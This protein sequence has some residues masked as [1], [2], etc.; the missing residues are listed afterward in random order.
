MAL[1]RNEKPP[2]ENMVLLS[3]A[4]K[5]SQHN[6]H[7]FR[8]DR[9]DGEPWIARVYPPARP[10]AGVEGDAAI[11]RFLEQ[12]DYP[13]ERLA[14][15]QAETSPQIQGAR[16]ALDGALAKAK[17]IA[18]DPT[19][20]E[21]AAEEQVAA[22]GAGA[23]SSAAEPDQAASEVQAKPETHVAG[24]DEVARADDQP[25]EET[26]LAAP[27]PDGSS[28]EAAADEAVAAPMEPQPEAAAHSEAPPQA[29]EVPSHAEEPPQ[30]EAPSAEPP[31]V[32]EPAPHLEVV[33]TVEGGETQE[34]ASDISDKVD[35][36]LEELRE[37]T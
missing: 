13:A 9:G 23:P 10:E 22:A 4:T 11:L 20:L 1:T 6:D 2:Q 24:V 29:D 35:R 25:V 12:R 31:P 19:V 34:S 33:E 16:E 21:R 27:A 5:V 8:V 37:V 32:A 28:V 17:E 3:A 30:P 26:P 15:I 14:A 36:L 7:V 18:E